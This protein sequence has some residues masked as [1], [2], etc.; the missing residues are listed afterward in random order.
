MEKKDQE[1][2]NE[3]VPKQMKFTCHLC[4]LSARYDYYGRQPLDRHY[5][6]DKAME[7]KPKSRQSESI[8][9]IENCYVCDDPFD[10]HNSRSSF[11]VLGANCTICN[12]MVCVGPKCSF[13]YYTRRFCFRCASSADK[14][15]KQAEFPLEIRTE[16]HKYIEELKDNWLF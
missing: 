8:D 5:S 15:D 9:L 6:I 12:R 14:V 2:P 3:L 13:F 16:I 1:E 11:L 10:G 4:D 7:T